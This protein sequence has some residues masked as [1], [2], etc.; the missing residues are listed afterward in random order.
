MTEKQFNLLY[1]YGRDI[2][3]W[4]DELYGQIMDVAGRMQRGEIVDFEPDDE[5]LVDAVTNL[6]R[7]L[8]SPSDIREKMDSYEVK[9]IKNIIEKYTDPDL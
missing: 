2:F 8:K 7:N 6:M 4:G 3:G 5:R 9:T 1:F